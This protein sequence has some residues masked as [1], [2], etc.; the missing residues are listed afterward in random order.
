MHSLQTNEQHDNKTIK[1]NLCIILSKVGTFG[2]PRRACFRVSGHLVTLVA[3]DLLMSVKINN[4]KN[5]LPQAEPGLSFI[6]LLI[7]KELLE[8][9]PSALL[10]SP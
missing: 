2:V 3:T 6:T 10:L 9:F 8:N 5:I 7:K 1:W 4:G